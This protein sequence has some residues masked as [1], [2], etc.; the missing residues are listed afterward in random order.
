MYDSGLGT[1]DEDGELRVTFAG[2]FRF[3]TVAARRFAFV[4]LNGQ[5]R[6][7]QRMR[8]SHTRIFLLLQVVHPF[9]LPAI[10][11]ILCLLRRTGGRASVVTGCTTQLRPHSASDQWS[12]RSS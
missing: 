10:P 9:D 3:E 5:P 1:I 11:T 4:T 7:N 2:S 12:L 8:E 6:R